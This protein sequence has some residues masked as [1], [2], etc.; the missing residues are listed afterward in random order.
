MFTIRNN[1]GITR[2]LYTVTIGYT[3]EGHYYTLENHFIGL[4][5]LHLAT[6]AII[7]TIHNTFDGMMEKG[8]IE[9]VEVA[10]TYI[11]GQINKY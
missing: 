10:E 11:C 7:E 9:K 3:R 6:N 5:G 1:D 2:T 4:S 8:Y